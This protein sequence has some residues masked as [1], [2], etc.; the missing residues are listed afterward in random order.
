MALPGMEV[1][2]KVLS[3][4]R[5]P[6][7]AEVAYRLFDVRLFAGDC[8]RVVFLPPVMATAEVGAKKPIVVANA[9]VSGR[10]ASRAVISSAPIA[11]PQKDVLDTDNFFCMMLLLI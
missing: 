6:L 10:A 11:R 5:L 4:K 8:H 7:V 1:M 3:F 2:L 9:V